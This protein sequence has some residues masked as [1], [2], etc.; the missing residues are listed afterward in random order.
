MSNFDKSYDVVV[1]GGGPIGLSAAYHCAKAGK[2]VLVL[3]KSI[4]FN[5]SGSSGDFVRML[6]TMYTED[7]MADLAKET[8]GLWEELQQDSGEGMLVWMSGLLNFG[9][10]NYGA[11]GPE[12]S[13][14]M[15]PI[16][17]LDRLGMP[18]TLLTSKQIMEQYPFKNLPD[19]F[20]GIHAPDNGVINVPLLLRTLY[21]L[22]AAYGARLVQYADV[23]KITN[24]AT[25]GGV[26]VEF[27]LS[28]SEGEVLETV[29]VHSA[30]AA[31]T[32]NA[33]SNQV[34]QPSFGF[35]LDLNIWE[36]VYNYF[37]CN[38]GPDGCVF[39]SMW[40]QFLGD[41]DNDPTKN[42]LFYGFPATPWS[43]P[44]AQRIAVDYA[45]RQISDPNERREGPEPH[46]IKLTRDFIK[47]FVVGVECDN[48]CFTG[49]ALQTNVYDNMF[50]LDFVPNTNSNVA[51]FCA[52]WAMKFT[53]L[54]GKILKQLLVDGKTDYDISHF[55]ITRDN[56][57][58]IIKDNEAPK[59][60]LHAPH[61]SSVHCAPIPLVEETPDAAGLAAPRP[62]IRSM[63]A[64]TL[65]QRTVTH[66]PAKLSQ[67]ISNN[68][69][70]RQ[71]KSLKTLPSVG[72][73][74]AGM[75]GLYA[76]MILQDLGIDYHILEGNK[77]R[78]GGRIYTYRYP[79]LE[80]QPYPYVDLGAMRF[81]KLEI[82]DRLLS[83]QPWSL[84]SKLEKAG[85]K[86]PTVPYHLSNDNNIIYYNG[87]RIYRKDSL[88]NDPLYFSDTHNGG[89]G[90]AVPDKYCNVPYTE[91]LYKEYDKF[92][93]DMANDFDGG[94]KKL[95]E[96]DNNSTRAYL[97]SKGYEQPAINYFETMET[98]SGLYDMAFS[99]TIMDYFDFSGSEWL[100][101][102][103]GSDVMVNSMIKTLKS[104]N[105]EKGKF[106]T[107]VTKHGDGVTTGLDVYVKGETK[108]RTYGHVI[109][110]GTLASL[111]KMDLD[112][113]NLSH[114]KRLAIRT[115][116]HDHSVKIT[117][118]F[119][120]RWWEDST[121]MKGKPIFGGTTSTD[122]PVRN[123]VY[124]SYGT[125]VKDAAGVLIVSYTWAQDAS[126]IGSLVGDEVGE[127]E[128]IELCMNNLAQVHD[129]Q[130]SVLNKMLV[131]FKCWDWYNDD[132][133][134]GA[135]ALYS[136]AQFSQ[137]FPSLTKPTPDGRFHLAGEGTS[138]HHGWVIGSLNSAYRAVDHV[139]MVEG[140]DDLRKKLRENW[141]TIDEVEDPYFEYSDSSYVDPHHNLSGPNVKKFRSNIS[142]VAVAPRL[143]AA[144]LSKRHKIPTTAAAIGGLGR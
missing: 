89:Q 42:N 17:N 44:N 58:L 90:T 119:N 113:L 108:P 9:D 51:I 135:F 74:G 71:K 141:G 64:K 69:S 134:M 97:Y 38:P 98:G 133:A 14:L 21:R 136:P 18:Y 138:V 140:L 112:D 36:M 132:F 118:A 61:G 65:L 3:E 27:V 13:T 7:F 19:Y 100:A 137:L 30:K 131:D 104:A 106:V 81:P 139:L 95:L 50:V 72:I 92:A 56:S 116:H 143:I 39:K 80:K 127:K 59:V 84:F 142:K 49:Y 24:N 115:L 82:M 5:S 37:N 26:D 28:N 45:L 124:P 105:I 91:I 52:G 12:G 128:L 120:K 87:K 99:E 76:A 110:T 122:L 43:V 85:H 48:P 47:N 53:P 125:G 114:N 35:K 23:K 46:D 34:L 22:S 109:S 63:F 25:K 107:K 66:E 32:T 103:G 73:I 70:L 60:R 6:R 8:L 83:D 10:P 41:T 130:V 111:R 93:D 31:I 75:S 94:F 54:I 102:E 77:D 117:L 1:V 57:R 86:I 29:T 129:I 15:D 16:K 2:K 68:R 4:F 144:C 67:V 123:I 11:G 78:Y 40:F 62:S 126:R 79:K 55:A 101:I 20:Q 88:K 96:A 121:F 33:F